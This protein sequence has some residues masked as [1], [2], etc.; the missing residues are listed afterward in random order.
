MS[1]EMPKVPMIFPSLSRHGI[2]VVRRPGNPA[3]GVGFF[4]ELP[5]DRFAG[6]DDFLLV[7]VTPAG[8]VPP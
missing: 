2:L 4:L 3:I 1:L 7:F 8:R 6:A 5:D